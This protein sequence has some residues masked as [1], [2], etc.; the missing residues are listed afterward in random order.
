MEN[1]IDARKK[2]A[3]NHFKLLQIKKFYPNL[4]PEKGQVDN[5]HDTIVVSSDSEDEQQEP[6][7]GI[8]VEPNTENDTIPTVHPLPMDTEPLVS[9]TRP[10]LPRYWDVTPNDSGVATCYEN[11][12]WMPLVGK[13]FEITDALFTTEWMLLIME[14]LVFWVKVYKP[15][16]WV[17]KQRAFWFW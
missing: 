8:Q 2:K 4:F 11:D 16:L 5:A 13:T 14:L 10:D 17:E 7:H 6:T 3:G 15:I 9:V 12:G 1:Y